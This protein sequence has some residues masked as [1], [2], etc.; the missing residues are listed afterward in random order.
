MKFARMFVASCL[1]MQPAFAGAPEVER[2]D[3]TS[4]VKLEA[5]V[6]GHLEQLNNKFKLRAS[7]TVY[8][9]G[10][11]IGEHHHVGPGIRYIASGE[12]TYIQ[13]DRTTI[14]RRVITSTSRETSPTQQS[15]RVLNRSS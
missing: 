4:E 15:T 11:Y 13:G 9:P 12:L 2:H 6:S 8:Q 7:E 10:G 1:L 3:Q 14:Y 5:A